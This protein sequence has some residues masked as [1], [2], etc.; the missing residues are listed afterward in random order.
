[1][2]GNG[3]SH[4]IDTTR[5]MSRISPDAPALTIGTNEKYGVFI[6]AIKRYPTKTIYHGHY[7]K[8]PKGK[9]HVWTKYTKFYLKHKKKHNI[10]LIRM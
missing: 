4:P 2:V 7:L 5:N 6:E 9:L 10:H 8:D 3:S 1:M